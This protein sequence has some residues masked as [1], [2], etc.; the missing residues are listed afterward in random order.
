MLIASNYKTV[1]L[2]EMLAIQ[3]IACGGYSYCNSTG[4]DVPLGIC[5]PYLGEGNSCTSDNDKCNSLLGLACVLSGEES[6]CQYIEYASVGQACPNNRSC[7]GYDYFDLV[8]C[9]NG[10]CQLMPDKHCFYK[11]HCPFGQYC[12]SN[13]EHRVCLDEPKIGDKSE[14]GSMCPVG[15]FSSA[16]SP[17]GYE[18]TCVAMLSKDL[19]EPCSSQSHEAQIFD[20]N[21]RFPNIDCNISKGLICDRSSWTCQ[22]FIP[23]PASSNCTISGCQASME[24]FNAQ[25]EELESCKANG[26]ACSVYSTN[27]FCNETNGHNAPGVCVEYLGQGDSCISDEQ[28]CNYEMGLGCLGD[29]DA[30]TCQFKDYATLG[31]KCS[32]N[33][34]CVGGY[35]SDRVQCLDGTCQ[36]TPGS[37]CRYKPHC[38]FGQYCEGGK[39]IAEVKIGDTCSGDSM[40]PVGA[41]CSPTTSSSSSLFKCVAVSSKQLGEP[42]GKESSETF[43]MNGRIPE[44]ECDISK[45]LVCDPKISACKLFIATPA[46]FNCTT[47]NKDDTCPRTESCYCNEGQTNIAS[48]QSN[49]IDSACGDSIQELIKCA[50]NNKCQ[51]IAIGYDGEHRSAKNCLYQN[52]ASFMCNDKCATNM[53]SKSCSGEP[54]YPACAVASSSIKTFIPS[55]AIVFLVAMLSIVLL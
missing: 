50:V 42:C 55:V 16:T 4:S 53:V 13:G 24:T 19:G 14:R 32:Y 34:S 15:S 46:S 31:M 21:G 38:L 26:E 17:N 37:Q 48:C 45:G 49:N 7:I 40:C 1:Y 5:T 10:T 25:C 12:G 18:Y 41:V 47:A 8:H 51:S 29:G 36:L 6:T 43:D 3:T 11:P 20:L 27:S 2:K 22:P 33:E 23:T 35:E 52:C 28:K 9:F 39:C 30:K 44:V 54:R